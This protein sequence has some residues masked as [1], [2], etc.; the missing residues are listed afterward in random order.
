MI[1]LAHIICTFIT[2]HLSHFLPAV[3]LNNSSHILH[4]NGVHTMDTN[5]IVAACSF[6]PIE[7]L[8]VVSTKLC[9]ITGVMVDINELNRAAIISTNLIEPS[10]ICLVQL[11]VLPPLISNDNG[12]RL[13]YASTPKISL[14]CRSYIINPQ[15]DRSSLLSFSFHF[16]KLFFIKYC[17]F[18]KFGMFKGAIFA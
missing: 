3:L 13:T 7:E 9:V 10:E 17:P 15:L 8:D 5:R 16:I 14:G 6:E 11:S 12:L 1:S 4:T 2:N 18:Q